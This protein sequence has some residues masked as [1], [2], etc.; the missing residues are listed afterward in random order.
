MRSSCIVHLVVKI[1]PAS[2][3]CW[4]NYEVSID[5]TRNYFKHEANLLTSREK[6]ETDMYVENAGSQTFIS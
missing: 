6:R 1:S 3:N 2:F 4:G 5:T